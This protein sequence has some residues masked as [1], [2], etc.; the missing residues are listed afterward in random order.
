M[1]STTTKHSKQWSPSDL[2]PHQQEVITSLYENNKLVIAQAGAG[3]T[4]C[5]Q[6]VAQEL[7]DDSELTR[8]IIFAP[9]KVCQLTWA[10]EF[11]DWTHLR[12][13]T[14]ALGNAN[15]RRDAVTGGTELVCMNIDNMAWFFKEFGDKHGFDGL[16]IDEGSKL[17]A[18]GGAGFKKLRYRLK[19]FTWRCVMSATPVHEASTDI[20]TQIMCVDGGAALGRSKELFQRKYFMSLDYQNRKWGFQPGGVERLTDDIAHLVCI[21]DTVDYEADLPELEDITVPVLMPPEAREVYDDFANKM[22]A[23]IDGKDI[24]A[25][26]LAVQSGKM[27]QVCCG[28][29][30]GEDKSTNWL[31]KAKFG[32][33]T[34][35]VGCWQEPVIIVYQYTY[36]KEMLQAMYTDALV[37][38]DDP[39]EAERAW[40]AGECDILLMHPKSGGHGLNLQKGGCRMIWMSPVWSADQWDQCIRRI[41]RRGQPSPVVW[42]YTLVVP[43]SVEEFILD[44]HLIKMENASTFVDHLRSK[45]V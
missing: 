18:A 34:E 1:S 20:Y 5:S 3:K 30:Y 23:E 44:R 36:E 42:R 8:V 41:W 13:V 4:V 19:D 2:T 33:L 14:M 35:L 25:V 6:T 21:M 15:Q 17:K 29:V 9:L 45:T 32:Q 12:P 28:A 7:I 11:N 24:E 43:D 27:Q 16:I 31:H 22:L 37:L 26:N 39:V 38:G 40:S 10:Q